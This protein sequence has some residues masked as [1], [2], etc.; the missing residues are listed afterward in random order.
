MLFAFVSRHIPTTEQHALAAL[1]GITLE[2]VGDL[3]AFTIT[4]ADIYSK[5]A[6]EGVIVV[7]PAAAL[8]LSRHFLVGVFENE[9][10][11][12]EGKP[13]T[14]KAKALH[15]FDFLDDN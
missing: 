14:F 3:D 10:R 1:K 15:M 12:E 4:T 11:A 13:P 8:R 7:H 9:M 5:I 6:A 2:H